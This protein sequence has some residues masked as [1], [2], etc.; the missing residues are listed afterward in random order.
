MEKLI[1]F[2]SS[3]P[4]LWD[5]LQSVFG[6]N[7]DKKNIYKRYLDKPGRILEFGCATGNIA[8]A[9]LAFDYVG[10][11]I[12]NRY[13]SCAKKKYKNV[14]NFHFICEDILNSGLK[15]DSFDYVLFGCTA[16]HLSDEYI[17]KIF[18]EFYR[19][20]KAN[21]ILILVDF[22]KPTASDSISKRLLAH[23]DRG[24]WIRDMSQYLRLLE[25]QK[26]FQITRKEILIARSWP[27]QRVKYCFF[28]L[29]K[30]AKS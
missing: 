9:F 22:L 7:K 29:S 19:I 2:V 17:Y 4:F 6:S 16:H 25:N 28:H 26:M 15:S 12:N 13:I 30:I 21:G 3:N 8:D 18:P 11:D 23:F 14:N 5:C 20:L 24:Q 27:F 1:S 10:I